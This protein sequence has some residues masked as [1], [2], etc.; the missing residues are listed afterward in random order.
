MIRDTYYEM[1]EYENG[2]NWAMNVIKNQGLEAANK[3]ENELYEDSTVSAQT[4]QG[5]I[6]AI[7]NSTF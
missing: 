4:L 3:L 1:Q 2:Y 5:F 7:I 6:Q